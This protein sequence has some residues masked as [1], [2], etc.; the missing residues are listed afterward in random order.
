ML[1]VNADNTIKLTRGDTAYLDI[2]VTEDSTG[3]PYVMKA[4]DKL[5]MTVKK[6]CKD[7][8]CYFSKTVED[9]T[10]IVIEPV[11]TARLAFGNYMYDVQLDTSAGEV[12]TV[13]EPACFTIMPE[14]T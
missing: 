1:Y 3:E 11:D 5:T 12:F 7:S 6:T 2:T 8:E 10:L 9:S 4:G 14:V 13:I